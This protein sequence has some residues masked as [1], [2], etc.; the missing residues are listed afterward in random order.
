MKGFIENHIFIELS[1][2]LSSPSWYWVQLILISYRQASI[3]LRDLFVFI[4]DEHPVNRPSLEFIRI[5]SFAKI[6]TT[7]EMRKW[8]AFWC[9]KKWFFYDHMFSQTE[10]LSCPVCSAPPCALALRWKGCQIVFRKSGQSPKP[11]DVFVRSGDE[12]ALTE[13]EVDVAFDELRAEEG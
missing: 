11:L 5:E 6:R 12:F 2:Q 8:L 7:W 10:S 9:H 1:Y 4:L 3:Q 13:V